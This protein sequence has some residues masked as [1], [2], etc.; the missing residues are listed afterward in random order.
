MLESLKRLMDVDS[1]PKVKHSSSR[2]YFDL[3]SKE[4]SDKLC[5]WV[6]ELYLELHR[7]TYTTHAKVYRIDGPIVLEHVTFSRF[8]LLLWFYTSFLFLQIK[9]ENRKGEFLLHDVDFLAAIAYASKL[10][11]T[12][13]K[14]FSLS[15]NVLF[16]QKPEIPQLWQPYRLSYCHFGKSFC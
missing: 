15:I 13:S 4:D 12:S 14:W 10:L 16:P 6:G 7:G 9:Q 1:L 11:Y 3:V 5:K 8:F 2:E